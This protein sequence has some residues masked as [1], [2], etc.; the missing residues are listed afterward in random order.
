MIR[1]QIYLDEKM[2]EKIRRLAFKFR[3][4]ESE[5]IRRALEEYLEKK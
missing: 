2:A 1:K 3:I 5:I 4:T